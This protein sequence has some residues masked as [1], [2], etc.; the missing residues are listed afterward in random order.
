M[1]PYLMLFLLLLP[2]GALLSQSA[3]ALLREGN[4]AYKA[5]QYAEAERAYR[6]A[7]E[8]EASAQANYNLGNALFQQGRYEEAAERY[9]AAVSTAEE[10]Q[11]K[12]AAYY[13]LGNAYYRQGNYPNSIEA[14]KAALRLRPEDNQAKQ[15]LLQTQ[16]ALV[17]N[18]TF[19][20]AL[21][22]KPRYEKAETLQAGQ[23]LD[24]DI[25]VVNEGDLAAT[26]VSIMDIILPGFQLSDPAWLPMGQAAVY[27]NR[28]ERLPAG[29]SVTISIQVRVTDP[30]AIDKLYNAAEILEAG[31]RWNKADQDST[32]GNASDKPD[33]DDFDADGPQQQQS[34]QQQQQQNQ[35]QQDQ[36]SEQQD[37]QQAQSSG[38][39]EQ[40][41][42]QQ[43]Q[44]APEE[45]AEERQASGGEAREMSEEEA[46][47]LLQIIEE[48]ELQVLKKLKKNKEQ[49]TKREKDW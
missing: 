12:A 9:E 23:V 38:E 7:L 18:G 32:P 48:E 22:L 16:Q 3:H 40:Q 34:Q 30:E 10:E 27:G 49:P 39:Q 46:R 15:N 17:L 33:E 14:Y 1:K 25:T 11:I 8:A 5:G 28:I 6:S 44:P 31:N 19:D 29:D 45:S 4:S 37:E 36:E 42:Q 43:Q 24:Y 35:Q 2:G 26:G 47:R 21:K 20:L 13:N 41:S